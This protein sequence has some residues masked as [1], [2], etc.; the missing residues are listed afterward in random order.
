MDNPSDCK[1]ELGTHELLMHLGVECSRKDVCNVGFSKFNAPLGRRDEVQ[2]PPG[3]RSWALRSLY[4]ARE[5]ATKSLFRIQHFL[6]QCR[7]SGCRYCCQPLVGLSPL[8][9]AVSPVRLLPQAASTQQLIGTVSW[10]EERKKT[11]WEI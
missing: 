1:Q 2:S 6:P 7:E 10:L 3:E 9:R 4:G 5:Y 11:I 8:K